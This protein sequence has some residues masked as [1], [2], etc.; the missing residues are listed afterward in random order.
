MMGSGGE[1]AR[2]TVAFLQAQRRAGRRGAGQAVPAVPG[3]ERS[4]RRC[5]ASVRRVAVLDRT[6]EPG[7]L[8][9]PLFLDV[10]AA[11]SEA[12]ADGERELMPRVIGGR[13]GLSSKEFTPGMVAGVLEE[14]RPRA[15]QAAVHDRDQRRRLRH[16]P[17]LRPLAR[18]RARRKR[19]GRCSSAWAPTG[20]SARTRTRSRSSATRRACTPRATSSTTPRSR[21]R[22]RSRTC[23]SA[24]SRSGPRTWSRGPASSAA[25]SSGCSSA[26]RC[27]SGPR[28]ERR[29][30]STA[31][32]PPDQV[33]DAL[34]R[35]VQEQILAKRIELYVID[36]GPD[37]PRGGAG[38]ADQHGAADLLLR[39]L[40]RARAGPGDRADQGL[41]REDLRRRGAE[42]VERNQRAVDQRPRRVCTGWSCR[43]R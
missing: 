22:R 28:P 34:S 8:G 24:R 43:A 33:W 1:T 21:A 3:R 26:P 12:H 10:L 20:P 2:E 42:V 23:A 31:T 40:R 25:T 4:W 14:L 6:K 41:D 32:H 38:R 7:S 30:C 11:L 18:H 36:A 19:C 37:R 29:C 5:P 9:E 17:A 16:E 13:Y 35:P 27:S 39:D 15:A